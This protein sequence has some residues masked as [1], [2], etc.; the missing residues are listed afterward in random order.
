[1]SFLSDTNYK[2]KHEF[3]KQMVMLRVKSNEKGKFEVTTD[4]QN[5][6]NFLFAGEAGRQLE[7]LVLARGNRVDFNL[8]NI[9]F[10]DSAGFRVLKEIN[11]L[12]LAKGSSFFLTHVGPDV[13]ELIR[14]LGLTNEF[15]LAVVP[16]R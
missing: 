4:K 7:E 5:R 14:L 13:M 15:N 6:F 12:A 11:R 16:A 10:I 8:E 2:H 1:M 3:K 9:K